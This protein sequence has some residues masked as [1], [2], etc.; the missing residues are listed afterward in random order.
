MSRMDVRGTS[1]AAVN[2]PLLVRV[3]DD[4]DTLISFVDMDRL[5]SWATGRKVLLRRRRMNLTQSELASLAGVKQTDV[6]RAEREPENTPVKVFSA[7]CRVY[8]ISLNQL[9]E[10]STVVVNGTIRPRDFRDDSDSVED[11]R[12]T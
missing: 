7:L 11:T 12:A 10:E 6:S 4:N 9:I 1:E 5:G 3:E 2:A 8:N